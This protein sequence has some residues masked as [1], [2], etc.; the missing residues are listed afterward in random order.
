[1]AWKDGAP[2]SGRAVPGLGEFKTI[3]SNPQT[4]NRTILQRDPEISARKEIW[5]R[6]EF[7][8]STEW[9]LGTL[10]GQDGES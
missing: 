1:V 8:Y 9:E 4:V 6:T 10:S 3:R 2:S 5:K 7:L